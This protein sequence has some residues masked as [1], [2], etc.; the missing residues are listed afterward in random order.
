MFVK[1]L[2]KRSG[3][4]L[5][6]GA[7]LVLSAGCHSEVDWLPLAEQKIYVAD[8]FFDVAIL[9]PKNAIV[10]GYGGKMITT[11]DGGFTWSQVDLGT[12]KSLYSIDFAPDGKTGWV[13]GQ[14]GTI[15]RTE[16]AGKTWTKQ[17]TELWLDPKCSDPD[18][19]K[20]RLE[21]PE[22]PPCQHAYLF[23]V[24]VIDENTAH[25]IGDK[26]TYSYTTDGGKTWHSR[27]LKVTAVKEVGADMELALEDPVLYDVEFVD[28]SRGYIVG[29]FGK[30]YYTADGGQSFV[31]Q[32]ETLM[33][34]TVIDI[35]DLPTLFDIEFVTDQ[36]GIVA[37]L[38]GRIAE[39]FDGGQNWD[40]LP[41]NV[42]DYVDPFYSA[43]I[44][45]DGMRWVVGAS[46]QAVKAATGE[47]FARADLGSRVNNW[48]RRVRFYKD[49]KHGWLVGGFGLI[50]NTEDGG[51]TWYR[52]IG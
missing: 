24:N 36:H 39:T 37:G 31:E 19:R 8:K 18:E 3:A 9:D 35:L 47:P 4:S 51:K 14:E 16:D 26:S 29:E 41:N 42:E 34:D 17:Y 43:T 13:V 2:A 38:D 40:F 27:V 50:M 21:D 49:D 33:D 5:A 46:G 12:Q 22:A 1:N 10:V 15:L 20:F 32:Q 45:S 7:A 11:S 28:K 44:L 6:L 48:M 25:I 23:A 52:R 30:I